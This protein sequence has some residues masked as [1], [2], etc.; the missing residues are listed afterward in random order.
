MWS[1]QIQSLMTS[2]PAPSSQNM[3]FIED[4]EDRIKRPGPT[5][6]AHEAALQKKRELRAEREKTILRIIR[7][8]GRVCRKDLMEHG[9]LD[10]DYLGQVANRMV[11][12]DRLKTT[13]IDRIQYWE[14]P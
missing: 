1:T 10:G 5:P 3:T 14:L 12:E 2:R 13:K 9:K 11:R 4:D 7:Q 8:L 6:K